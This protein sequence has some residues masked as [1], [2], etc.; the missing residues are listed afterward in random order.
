MFLIPWIVMFTQWKMKRKW[1]TVTLTPYLLKM[2]W[3]WVLSNW[4]AKVMVCLI[5]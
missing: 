2:V 5:Q 1:V 3:Q 4:P